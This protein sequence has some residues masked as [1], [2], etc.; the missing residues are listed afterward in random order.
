MKRKKKQKRRQ[1]RPGVVPKAYGLGTPVL[2]FDEVYTVVPTSAKSHINTHNQTICL[3][4][5]WQ[6]PDAVKQGVLK[7]L[8]AALT[9]KIHER[10]IAYSAYYGV[11]Y[12]TIRIKNIRSR[13]GSCSSLGNLNFNLQ[14]AGASDAI[15]DYI[16]V[17]EIC[18]LRH[19]NHSA[20]FWQAV[21]ETIPD[22][23]VRRKWLRE[24]GHLL[25]LDYQFKK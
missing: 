3:N 20:D 18:H 23:R 5:D 9:T 4:V 6:N 13:W 25:N 10:V 7:L 2:Y 22:W 14:L 1:L 21:E 11:S 8:R 19:L 12:N 24:N 16:V 17:H 15:V